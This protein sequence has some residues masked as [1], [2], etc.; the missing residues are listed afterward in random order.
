MLS[1]FSLKLA[2]YGLSAFPLEES[3]IDA[4][5]ISWRYLREITEEFIMVTL[6]FAVLQLAY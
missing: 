4:S 3:K 6:V 5:G 2:S 1:T